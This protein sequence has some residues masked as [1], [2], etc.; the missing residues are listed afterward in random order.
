MNIFKV[1]DVKTVGQELKTE[2]ASSIL[3]INFGPGAEA[4]S[5]GRYLDSHMNPFIQAVHT[6]FDCHR[7]LSLSPDAVW[8][9]IAQG[10][11]K[12]IE[13]NAEEL[14][15]KFVDFDGKEELIVRRDSFI[16]G[17]CDNNWESVFS[18]FSE[19]LENYIGKKRNLIVSDFETTGPIEKAASEIVLMDAMKQYF[20]FTVQTLCGFPSITLEGTVDDWKNIRNRVSCFNEFGL[21][22]WTQE[23][24]PI[25]D[26]FVRASEDH[27]NKDFWISFLKMGGGSGGDRVNGWINVFFPYLENSWRGL[28]K[29]NHVAS[30]SN[31]SWGPPP[32]SFPI[33]LSKVPFRWEY[34]DQVFEMEFVGGLIGVSQEEDLTLSPKAG[35]AIIDVSNKPEEVNKNNLRKAWFKNKKGLPSLKFPAAEIY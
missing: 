24:I 31:S 21:D 34:F 10:L 22:W 17:S 13:L 16:K 19:K 32:S 15:S 7:P 26:E 3:K 29:N 14:R 27:I 4:W 20:D 2:P 12:H 6:A 33:G 1:N 30:Y 28:H 9:V 23:L 35:W 18:E 5:K 25:L 11:A 8:L